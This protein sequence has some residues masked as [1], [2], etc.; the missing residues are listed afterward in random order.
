M[1]RLLT[2]LAF[3]IELPADKYLIGKG[4]KDMSWTTR[5]F[6]ISLSCSAS[7][8]IQMLQIEVAPDAFWKSY[9]LVLSK[10][11]ALALAP[12]CWFDI[13]LNWSR[14]KKWYYQGQNG[15]WWDNA[16]KKL[17]ANHPGFNR[18]FILVAR[19]V[20]FVGLLI[21]GK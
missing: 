4:K 11:F 1:I 18:Y 21:Y 5:V 19:A 16:I 13:L 9:Y 6:I 20:A 14:G 15:K 7:A 2:L 10:D 17:Y 12:Y 8:G 3:F